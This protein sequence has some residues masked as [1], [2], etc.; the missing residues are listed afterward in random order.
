MQSSEAHHPVS[1]M[2]DPPS[3]LQ[4]LP[5]APS[6]SVASPLPCRALAP[7]GCPAAAPPAAGTCR[8]SGPAPTSMPPSAAG[9]EPAVRRAAEP[10]RGSAQA[11]YCWGVKGK[12]RH[13]TGSRIIIWR[14][15]KMLLYPGCNSVHILQ[16]VRGSR[17]PPLATASGPVPV[18]A[19]LSPQ[20]AAPL[21]SP[22][23]LEQCFA[24]CVDGLGPRS[25]AG[26]L[27]LL[28]QRQRQQGG[29]ACTAVGQ[30][31]SRHAGEP[32]NL[33]ENLAGVCA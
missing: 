14:V 6:I 4:V 9:S 19:P 30:R 13:T 29:L 27:G 7:A 12:A 26:Q 2:E 21:P 15:G 24:E 22:P 1:I 33:F 10:V 5:S 8:T 31:M 3:P 32:H 25:P 28:Q 20:T 23:H 11:M 18:T 17:L 16:P